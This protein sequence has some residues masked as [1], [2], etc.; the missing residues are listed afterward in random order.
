MKKQT[1]EHTFMQEMNRISKGFT[2][3]FDEFETPVDGS[4]EIALLHIIDQEVGDDE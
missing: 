2:K 3:K 1:P 4:Q